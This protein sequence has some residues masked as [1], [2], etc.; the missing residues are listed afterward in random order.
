MRGIVGP[1]E[2]GL[3]TLLSGLEIISHV[4]LIPASD[5]LKAYYDVY[6]K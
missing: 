1:E 5:V 3:Q 6:G 2:F 4:K